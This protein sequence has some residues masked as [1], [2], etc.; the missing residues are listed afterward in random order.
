ME[1][2]PCGNP[3]SR[4]GRRRCCTSIRVS[5]MIRTSGSSG[6]VPAVEVSVFV[7]DDNIERFYI[8]T[9]AA[10]RTDLAS[11]IGAVQKSNDSRRVLRL[12]RRSC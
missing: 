3:Q 10:R 8:R 11:Q 6:R 1:S 4:I 5:R 12:A 2:V 9:G 7:K